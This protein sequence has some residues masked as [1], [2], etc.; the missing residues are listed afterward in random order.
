RL[1]RAQDRSDLLPGHL[2]IEPEGE[3]RLLFRLQRRAQAFELVARARAQVRRRRCAHLLDDA[4]Q[5][6]R[7]EAPPPP[8]VGIAKRARGGVPSEL[9]GPGPKRAL[10]SKRGE[11]APEVL[12]ERGEGL[13]GERVV[14]Q[15][16]D[17]IAIDLG[18]IRAQ[19]LLRRRLELAPLEGLLDLALHP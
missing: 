1:R 11:P 13:G 5:L 8:P 19:S 16:R 18:T 6:L 14:A 3:E 7:L 4:R 9:V 15:D 10:S 12:S 2:P 17:E